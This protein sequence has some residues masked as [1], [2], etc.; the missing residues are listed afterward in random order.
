M[1]VLHNGQLQAMVSPRGAKLVSLS[2]LTPDGTAVEL[3]QPSVDPL[4]RPQVL[5][6]VFD[7]RQAWGGDICAPSVSACKFDFEGYHLTVGDHGDFW[8]KHFQVDDCSRSSHSSSSYAEAA[9]EDKS[10]RAQSKEF[11]LTV[12]YSLEGS[13]LFRHYTVTNR[14]QVPLPFL[15]AD[16]LLFPVD[17][18]DGLEI[19]APVEGQYRVE[20][21]FADKLG[22]RGDQ[23]E[24]PR[25]RVP[26]FADKLFASLVAAETKEYSGGWKVCRDGQELWVTLSSRELAFLGYWH[27]EGGWHDQYNFGLELTSSPHD[28]LQQ[29][30]ADGSAWILPPGERRSWAIR[31]EV[32]LE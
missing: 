25:R 7:E 28:D 9:S 23:V 16:H 12:C 8:Q 31:L 17:E 20:S 13:Q 18:W 11:T 15:F 30:V 21:S 22:R 26:P 14:T 29:A 1:I 19:M 24:F 27:T 2:W 3:L 32:S 5:G 4:R 10:L 6:E